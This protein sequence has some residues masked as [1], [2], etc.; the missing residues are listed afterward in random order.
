MTALRHDRPAVMAPD[1]ANGIEVRG[2]TK[3]L[4]GRSILDSVDLVV[5]RG[6]IA[7]MEGANGAGKTTLVR[8]L[9][10]V[11][12][13]DSGTAHVNGFDVASQSLAVRRSIG[14]SFA[15][16][17]SLYWRINGFENLE[18][19][20]KIAGLSK[21]AISKRSTDLLRSLHLLTVAGERVARMSTGQRQRLMVARALMTNPAVVLLDEPFR[22]LDDEGLQA[23]IELVAKR[24][25]R[26]MTALIVAPIIDAVLPIADATYTIDGGVIRSRPV[27]VPD[28]VRAET[29]LATESIVQTESFVRSEIV[30]TEGILRAETIV[31]AE[32]P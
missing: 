31:P 20:G 3:A 8:V 17:R 1:P 28:I 24:T 29:V 30:R 7:V 2:V 14:V 21:T 32:R 16:E 23:V 5:P 26:G 4:R 10:T 12:A 9:A 18:R 15:N 27:D 19:F 22:G 25:S 13:P 11:V 6:S